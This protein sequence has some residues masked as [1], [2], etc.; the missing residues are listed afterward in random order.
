MD[1]LETLKRQLIED[2]K[3]IKELKYKNRVLQETFEDA[4][5][6]H[7]NLL[8]SYLDLEEERDELSKKC[9]ELKEELDY[10]NDRNEKLLCI[11]KKYTK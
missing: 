2:V 3:I 7:S 1:D 6:E 5:I 9:K 4:L 10:V 8:E 11:I